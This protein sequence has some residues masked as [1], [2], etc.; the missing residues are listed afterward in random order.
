MKVGVFFIADPGSGGLYQY[1]LSIM[2]SLKNSS[3]KLAINI[4]M[5]T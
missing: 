5:P 1:A 2:D 3:D 4:L